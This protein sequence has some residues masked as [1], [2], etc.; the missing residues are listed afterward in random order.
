[1]HISDISVSVSSCSYLIYLYL[2]A[3]FGPGCAHETLKE[4]VSPTVVISLNSYTVDNNPGGGSPHW[5]RKC[6]ERLGWGNASCWY[7][8]RICLA[9][10]FVASPPA[11][12]IAW[13]VNWGICHKLIQIWDLEVGCPL[14]V[15]SE[16]QIRSGAGCVGLSYHKNAMIFQQKW[17]PWG[18]WCGSRP[19]SFI[20]P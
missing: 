20:A 11:P 5:S 13:H 7:C 16:W 9:P 10:V 12:E 15:F 2:S 1:M 4:S 6:L 18:N 8:A 14:Q 3:H 17:R 19:I